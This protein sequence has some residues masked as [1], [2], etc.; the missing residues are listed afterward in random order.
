VTALELERLHR[1]WAEHETIA[2][3][4]ATVDHKKIGTRYLVTSS[5]FFLAG[6]VEALLMRAQLARPNEDLL[7]PEAYN[8]TFSMHGL[9]MIF[10]FVTPMLSGFANYFVPLQIGARGTWPSRA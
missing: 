9:T 1:S 10:L 5:L 7:T 4:L 3:R 2:T 8:Q 6:G